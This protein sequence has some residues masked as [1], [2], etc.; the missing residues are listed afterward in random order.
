MRTKEEL[1]K[2]IVCVVELGYIGLPL[3]ETISEHFRVIG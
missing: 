1:N 3:A 2:K